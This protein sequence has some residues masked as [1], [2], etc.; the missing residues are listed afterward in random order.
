MSD[1]ERRFDPRIT[2][3]VEFAEVD[4]H[5]TE[6]VANLSKGGIFLRCDAELPIG[7]RVKLQFTVLLDDIESIEGVGEVV[8]LKSDGVPGLGIRFIQLTE[9]SRLLVDRICIDDAPPG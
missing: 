6:Y 9:H 5:L 4:G 8:H 3:N 7:T 2:V 1:D